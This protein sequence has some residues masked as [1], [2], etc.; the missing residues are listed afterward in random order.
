[1]NFAS[2]PFLIG[3][4]PVV[5]LG[6][7]LIRGPRAAALRQAWLIG[8]SVV[9]YAVSGWS[10]LGVLAI[11]VL[12]N[13]AAGSALVRGQDRSQRW[14]LVVMWLGV[15]FNLGLLLSFKWGALI[16][17]ARNGFLSSP[18]I[19][20][21][22]AISFVTFQQIGFL[23][24]CHR[25]QV[26]VLGLFDYLFFATFFPHLIM[27]PIL[28]YPHIDGQLKA[29]AFT[30]VSAENMAVGLSIFLFG[31]SKKM[32]LADPLARPVN[33]VFELAM[34]GVQPT[35]PETWFAIIA[36][37]LQLYLDFSGYADMAIGLGRMVGINLPINFDAPLRAVDR[38]DLWRR[39]HITFV[40]F[41]RTNVFMPL[42][43]HAGF[44]PV[45]ALAATGILSGLWHGLGWTF[46]LWGLLQTGILLALHF[47][48][49]EARSARLG[50]MRLVAGVAITFLT[51]C[52]IG[53]LFR[54]P[55]L[56]AAEAIYGALAGVPVG[57]G[58]QPI[59][60]FFGFALSQWPAILAP[61]LDRMDAAHFLVAAFVIWV[62][63]DPIRFFRRYWTAHDP[64]PDAKSRAAAMAR[65]AWIEFRLNWR[66]ALVMAALAAMS[67]INLGEAQ[68][69]IYAQF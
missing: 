13:Y 67:V 6:F 34:Q 35:T 59:P 10:N 9:F 58:A 32:L 23:L 33:S 1:M 22:L 42:V 11:S 19:L 52:L 51:S 46:V 18:K 43:R 64:R 45:A 27:G 14:R 8:A 68:R 66:W 20:I 60:A 44:A 16:T 17:E 38:F 62:W 49:G 54:S 48:S 37:Q 12:T 5:I 41:M 30:R 63:P 40:M 69:F 3:F 53:A 36:F 31:L 55:S 39:W 24:A 65:P 50:P 25:R 21:P 15:A 7:L 2:W 47:R 4:L 29:G 28:Q 61:R 26:K 56:G 57:P